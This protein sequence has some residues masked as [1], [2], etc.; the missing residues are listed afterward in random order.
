MH[1]PAP[2]CAP[3][4]SIVV[5]DRE[6]G[7]VLVLRDTQ[8]VTDANAV[9]P[10]VLVPDRVALHRPAD[11]RA[12]RARG[13]ARSLAREVPIEVVVRPGRP[14]RTRALPRRTRVPRR[15]GR[16][17]SASSP[18]PTVRPATPRGGRIP[19][20]PGEARAGTSSSRASR[21]PTGPGRPP[22]GR[23]RWSRSSRRTSTPGAAR[24]ATV[25][26]TARCGRAAGRRRTPSCS[27]GR[28]TR[29]MREPFALCRKAF[30]TPL[31]AAEADLESIDALAEHADGF[32]PYA[33]QF[34]HKREH[35]LEF[36]AGL[37][38]APARRAAVPHRARPRRPGRA[39]G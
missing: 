13:V 8:G 14:A 23:G 2:R 33:D 27:S 3:S 17:S 15:R 29:P 18:R 7:K 9:I 39:P 36:Q 34:N 26:R 4:R 10:P 12:D 24:S 25:T 19:R 31:G 32:D 38:A 6:R 37:P 30:A 1:A 28:R 20:G 5:P 11:V 22:R 21:K 35:S 16:A